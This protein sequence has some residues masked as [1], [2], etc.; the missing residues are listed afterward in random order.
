MKPRKSKPLSETEFKTI[1]S[2]VT[3]LCVELVIQTPKGIVLALRKLPSWYKMWHLPGSSL[4]YKEKIKDAIL[5][6]AINEVGMKVTP[7]K[8][9]GYIEYDE[10]KERGFGHT[11]S[12]AFLCRGDAKTMKPNEDAF[13]VKAFDKLPENFI[14]E[15]RD[16]LK[17]HKIL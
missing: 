17:S 16:F 12:L 13:E 11:I 9:L 15:Q 6:I 5:R 8:F 10:E 14:E 1:Y 2:K 3:R 7:D 4:L